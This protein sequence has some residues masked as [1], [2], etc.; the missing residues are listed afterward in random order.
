MCFYNSSKYGVVVTDITGRYRR[1]L[2]Y[3]LPGV[4]VSVGLYLAFILTHDFPIGLGG[5]FIEMI[6]TII[7]NR[8]S[9]PRRVPNYLADGVPFAY[10]PLAMYLVAALDVFVGLSWRTISIVLPGLMFQA[11]LVPFYALGV[12]L[13][14]DRRA[15]SLATVFFASSPALLYYYYGAGL[16]HSPGMVTLLVGSYAGVHL[17]REGE[18]RWRWGGGVAFGLTLLFHP[19]HALFFGTTLLTMYLVWDRTRW[20]LVDGA[21]VAV[22]GVVL[23]SPWWA[24]VVGIHGTTPFF[25]ASSSNNMLFRNLVLSGKSTA[26]LFGYLT[27]MLPLVGVFALLGCVQRVTERRWFLPVWLVVSALVSP[28]GWLLMTIAA[29][30]AAGWLRSLGLTDLSFGDRQRQLTSAVL[31]LFVVAYVS[32]TGFFF[33]TGAA[34]TDEWAVESHVDADV[35]ATSEW[36]ESNT[37]SDATLVGIGKSAEWVPY[38]ANRTTLITPWGAEWAGGETYERNVRVYGALTS[39]IRAS[40]IDTKLASARVQPDYVYV[41]TEEWSRGDRFALHETVNGSARFAVAHVEQSVFLLAYKPTR[42]AAAATNKNSYTGVRS[43][44]SS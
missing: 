12:V 11:A 36:L 35:V 34:G 29:L 24:S 15:A 10:S 18:R 27:T 40:C 31:V 28:R 41:D 19:T 9:L 39:C 16:P 23:S 17:F 13:L 14:D 30:L 37:G 44:Y 5:L 42:T 22:L 21:T 43:G 25:S 32:M 4:A 26:T 1:E 6:D 20:G 8:F 3:L 38:L 2:P 7:A 33:V